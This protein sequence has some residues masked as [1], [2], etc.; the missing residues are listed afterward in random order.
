MKDSTPKRKSSNTTLDGYDNNKKIEDM[1]NYYTATSRLAKKI[2]LVRHDKKSSNRGV[3]CFFWGVFT[4]ALV[5]IIALFLQPAH[6]KPA[7][8]LGFVLGV[9]RSALEREESQR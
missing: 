1:K 8:A 3:Q 2:R 4:S 6:I 5:A 7:L 9:S